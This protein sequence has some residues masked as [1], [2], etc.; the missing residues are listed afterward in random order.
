MASIT[1]EELHTYHAIDREIFSRL[2]ITLMRDPAES[3]LVMALWL[4][5]EEK[6][7]PN[8][9]AKMVKLSDPLLEALA[10]EA[11]SCL[12]C[13]GSGNPTI[14]PNGVFPLTARIMEKDISFQMF[15]QNK[16]S[17]ISGI[18]N[19][20][21][22]VCSR[23]FTDIL[24]RVMG[25][26]SQV[27]S[28]QPLVIPGF[29]HSLFGRVTIVPRAMDHGFPVGGLWGWHPCNNVSEDDRT[30]F[31]TFSRGFPVSEDEVRELFTKICGDCVDS[32]HMQEN[33]PCNEQPLFA[34]MVLH[35]VTNVDQILNRRR[36]AKFRI[37]GKH[38][39][40]RKYERRE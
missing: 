25:S 20:L 14:P 2:V 22:T 11:V 36:I 32:V 8:I 9:I 21:N 15:H 18:K 29:P 1:L 27:I 23:I 10:G 38:I 35:S 19:F 37:N 5:L 24:Q 7:Y 26:T 6:G 17:T 28:N 40:A 31:L 34:R 4:W 12:N 3:L 33:V 39:W 30:L 16:F 13:L